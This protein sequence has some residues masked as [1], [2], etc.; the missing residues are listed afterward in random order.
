LDAAIVNKKI[1][2]ILLG[3]PVSTEDNFDVVKY[4]EKNNTNYV[5]SLFTLMNQYVDLE[6]YKL[7]GVTYTEY[8]NMAPL[9]KNIFLEHINYKV[10]VSN[11]DYEKEKEA[12]ELEENKANR[13]NESLFD[14]GG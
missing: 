13:S 1:Y 6:I 7:T 14:F 2:N 3:R 9:E 8:K 5:D 4:N 10:A 12:M 11:Y